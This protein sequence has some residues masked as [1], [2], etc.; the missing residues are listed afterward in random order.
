MEAQFV[1]GK[2]PKQT[3][4]IGISSIL[5][6]FNFEDFENF[7]DQ[8][9]VVILDDTSNQKNLELIKYL[10]SLRKKQPPVKSRDDE[11]G[12]FRLY[13]TEIGPLLI[14]DNGY[15]LMYVCHESSLPEI[16]KK[17]GGI[18]NES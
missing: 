9:G 3:L 11:Y 6:N 18:E 7:P 4:D 17:V 16:E 15:D 8:T 5:W 12:E 2:D 13:L 14:V 1:R 10:D